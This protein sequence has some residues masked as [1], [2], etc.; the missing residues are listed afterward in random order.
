[1]PIDKARPRL[2]KELQKLAQDLDQDM[3]KIPYQGIILESIFLV[4]LEQ[5]WPIGETKPNTMR[6]H[7]KHNELE[8]KVIHVLMKYLIISHFSR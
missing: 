8:M 5:L 6:L 7:D 2:R 4:I 1:M 3:E